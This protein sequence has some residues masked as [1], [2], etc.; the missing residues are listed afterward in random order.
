M[1]RACAEMMTLDATGDE[2]VQ[3]YVASSGGPL[4]LALALV[5]TIDLLGVPVH[6]TCLGRAEGS[7]IAVV[8]AGARRA[9]APHAQFHLT[10]PDL[11]VSGNASQLAAWAE[12]HRAQVARFVDRLAEATGRP[13]E[14]VE[15][16]L[17]VGRWLSAEEALGYGLI[18]QIW[19][20]ETDRDGPG[21]MPPSG[22]CRPFGFGP[23]SGP[24]GGLGGP[25]TGLA[26]PGTGPQSGR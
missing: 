20:R 15:A 18:D 2:V 7:V 13:V 24:S 21:R 14:H 11:S 3:L 22:P 9:A 25:G 26:G 19:G 17:S 1:G 4:H 5:D 10:E 16:D 6:V 12:H 8:A 23:R